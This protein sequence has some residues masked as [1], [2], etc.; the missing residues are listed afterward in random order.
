M[1]D[2]AQVC[3]LLK[4]SHDTSGLGHIHGTMPI[5]DH[6]HEQMEA[7]DLSRQDNILVRLGHSRDG[8]ALKGPRN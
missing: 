5:A 3:N 4:Y 1:Q 2:H 7:F 8:A 6:Y